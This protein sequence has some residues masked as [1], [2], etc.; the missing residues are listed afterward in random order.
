MTALPGREGWLAN[1]KRVYRVWLWKMD[2]GQLRIDNLSI[3]FVF[4]CQLSTVNCPLSLTMRPVMAERG[5]SDFIRS[6]NGSEFIANALRD[7]LTEI[8]AQT[9]FIP[10]GSPWENP[11]IERFNGRLRV[12]LVNGE[13]FTSLWEAETGK[14]PPTLL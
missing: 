4:H 10:P 11:F 13:Q 6:D 3:R 12:E 8:G 1:A 2:S 14:R 9:M 7:W 5:I